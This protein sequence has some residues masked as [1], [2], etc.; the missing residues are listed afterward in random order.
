MGIRDN[1]DNG[2]KFPF[3]GMETAKCSNCKQ[4]TSGLCGV[5]TLSNQPR[6]MKTASE[7]PFYIPDEEEAENHRKNPESYPFYDGENEKGGE[8]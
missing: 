5:L 1:A 7:C 3:E 6:R 4:C 2:E 8:Q